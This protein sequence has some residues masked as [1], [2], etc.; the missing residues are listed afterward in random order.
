MTL[1]EKFLN[2]LKNMFNFEEESEEAVDYASLKDAFEEIEEKEEEQEKINL[3]KRTLLNKLY[4]I[5]QKITVFENDFPDKFK[6]FSDK[7]EDLRNDYLSSLKKSENDLTF[8]IDPDLDGDKLGMVKLLDSEVD[9]FIETD[10]KFNVI[11]KSLEKLI[12]KLN[13]VYNTSIIRCKQEEKEKIYLQAMRGFKNAQKISKDFK[14]CYFILNNKQLK[15][16]MVNLLSY[17]DYLIFKIKIKNSSISSKEAINESLMLSEFKDFD[18]WGSFENYLKDEVSDLGELLPLFDDDELKKSYERKFKKLLRDLAYSNEE[19][20]SHIFDEDFWKNYFSFETSLIEILRASGIEDDKAKV[21]LIKK[22]NIS[23]NE[24]EI[25]TLPITNAYIA[26]TGLFSSTGDKRI[27]VIMKML[28]NI[29]N[30][31]TYK[32]IYFLL[33]LFNVVDLVLSKPNELTR[34]LDKYLKQNT[35]SQYDIDKKKLLVKEM[36]NKEYVAVFE[37]TD[38][39]INNIAQIFEYLKFDFIVQNNIVYLNSFYF[40]GLENISKSLE[41]YT[42]N[43]T[44]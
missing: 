35:Y 22:M 24:N 29:S 17:A 31:V 18:L 5:E 1:F 26:L 21:T 11:S 30:E 6:E 40:S 28:K 33:L 20:E 14:N 3:S 2:F 34:H 19:C 13:I 37:M 27:L 25:W 7:I 4:T 36:V 10:M 38:Y 44:V 32:E 8:D 41:I 16:R 39:E 43:I 9:K 23:V 42:K 15:E 12:L